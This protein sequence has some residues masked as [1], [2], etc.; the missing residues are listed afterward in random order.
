MNSKLKIKGTKG[1]KKQPY[2]IVF[3]KKK[4]SN[5]KLTRKV[6]LRIYDIIGET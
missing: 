2:K 4:T 5:Q 3:K 1:S 6:L